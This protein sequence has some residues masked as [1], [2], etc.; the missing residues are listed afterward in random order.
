[1]RYRILGDLEVRDVAGEPIALPG[2]RARAVL[3]TLLLR[4]GRLVS[5]TE[6]LESAWGDPDVDPAQLHKAVS[7]LRAAGPPIKIKTHPGSGY[8]VTTAPD[9]L[10][11]SVFGRFVE[12]AEVAHRLADTD[13]E[14]V[15]L[16]AALD[17]WRGGSPLA[18]VPLMAFQGDIEA[19]RRRRRRCA[20]SLF[21]LVIA[22]GEL[23]WAAEQLAGFVA[24]YPDDPQLCRLLMR[25]LYWDGHAE[26]AVA[27]YERYE[28]GTASPDPELR[29]FA[30]AVALRDDEQVTRTGG[31]GKVTEPMPQPRQLPAPPPYYV[32]RSDQRA[33]VTRLLR[34]SRRP[35]VTIAG[36]GGVGKTALA[37][38]S[39]HDVLESFPDGQLWAGLRGMSDRPADP[40]EV[41]AEFLRALRV[42]AVPATRPERAALFRSVVANRRM[43]ILLDDARDGAQVRD[44]LP[45]DG[46]SVVLVT[47]RRRLPDLDAPAHHVAPLTKLD[48]ETAEALFRRIVSAGSVDLSGERDAV[49]AVVRMCDGLPLALR[50][51]AFLR[52][53]GFHRTTGELQRRLVEQGTAG[54]AYG[55]ESVARTIGAGLAPLDPRGRRLFAGLGGLAMTTFAEWTAA[56]VLDEPGP[57]AGDALAQL[58]AIGLVE[59]AAG[60]GRYTF[61]ELTREYAR[62]RA[63]STPD[64]AGRVGRALLTLVRH[65]HTAFYDEDFDVAHSGVPDVEV[66]AAELAAAATDPYAW[67][68]RERRTIRATIG[69]SAA[70]GHTEVC[71]DLA[72]SAHE[73]YALGGYF[74]DWRS[75]HEIALAACRASGD[76]RG[77]G[78][79]LTMLGMPPLVASGR[80]G[81]SGVPELERAVRL[82]AETGEQHVLAVARRTLANALRRNGEIARPL[83]LFAEAL[84]H[85]RRSG[86]QVGSQLT[87]RFI[88]H[89][90]L[91]RGDAG[92][93]VTVLREAV[94][95]AREQGQAR[96]LAPA[97]YW[98]GQ[99]RLAAGDLAGAGAAFDEVLGLSPPE[100]GLAHA[101]AL[102]GLGDL[103]RAGSDAG[104]ARNR[105]ERA[106][107]LA[108]DGADAGLEGRVGLSIAALEASLGRHG[109]RITALHRA[110]VPIRSYGSITL[111]ARVEAELADAYGKLGDPASARAARDRESALYD[112]GEVPLGDRPARPL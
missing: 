9:D 6:L 58:A 64:V 2:G 94:R 16:R 7:A 111:E 37:L 81:V 100:S 91:D 8:A 29:H 40:A 106:E 5:T 14:V 1:M 110:L 27:V 45:G 104:P 17:L 23:A 95:L 47:A 85:H 101:Y 93:A 31:A 53:E 26:E 83:A 3:A 112:R 21:P 39:A 30:Y 11:A 80:T 75:T 65:A 96:V 99:A 59:P 10:D 105:L 32:G 15:C 67:F 62:G 68:E 57:A 60:P 92:P 41:L 69:Q 72:V 4:P 66:P 77:E 19:L 50:T 98:L 12:R 63:D 52:V 102:H 38:R 13:E 108:H 78:V 54:F 73:F 84:E 71:W 51:A 25:A 55:E 35:V 56:A 22:R 43:L 46:P 82:L 42:P 34:E 18:D 20:E 74:D 107:A 88:G 103:A 24:E 70:L 49:T 90:H 86:D 89:A 76:R 28:E 33:E 48:D 44:L 87:L 36:P 79:V 109:A 61:H 97:L